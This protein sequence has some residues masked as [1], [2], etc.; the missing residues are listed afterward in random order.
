M[1]LILILLT[2]IC[3]VSRAEAHPHVFLN[4]AVKIVSDD[5]RITA[6]EFIWKFDA[7][8]STMVLEETGVKGTGLLGKADTATLRAA[9]FDKTQSVNYFI[10][11]TLDDKPWT[12]DQIDNFTIT[13]TPLNLVYRFTVKLPQ[14]AKKLS[15]HVVDQTYY[16]DI[17]QM[18]EDAL[19]IPASNIGC[20]T[21]EKIVGETPYGLLR[22][23]QVNCSLKG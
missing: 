15:F 18:K 2:L 23:Q 17:W 13:R 6:L 3:F 5:D 14:P 10:A 11:A 9:A 4:Y 20:D 16:V 7:M 8:F 12:I 21:A 22:S 19:K 1:R